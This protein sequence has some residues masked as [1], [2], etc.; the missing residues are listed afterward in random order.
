MPLSLAHAT[1]TEN[2]TKAWSTSTPQTPELQRMVGSN[3]WVVF[4]KNSFVNEL[5][6]ILIETDQFKGILIQARLFQ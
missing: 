4:I 1:S 3:A 6:I 5:V 2:I